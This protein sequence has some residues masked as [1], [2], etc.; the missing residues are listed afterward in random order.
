LLVLG[1]PLDPNYLAFERSFSLICFYGYGEVVFNDD[2]CPAFEVFDLKSEQR[3]GMIAEE[4]RERA[5]QC[6]SMANVIIDARANKALLDLADEYD[7]IAEK[8]EAREMGNNP[9]GRDLE[10]G[11]NG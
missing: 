2:P 11:E 3:D 1:R 4:M 7:A 6:R 10:E 9:S 5:R 8:A